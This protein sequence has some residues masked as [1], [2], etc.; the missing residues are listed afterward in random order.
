MPI[1][2]QVTNDWQVR[3]NGEPFWTGF[4]DTDVKSLLVKAGFA[5]ERAVAEYEPLGQGAY[6]FFGGRK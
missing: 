2:K 3:N 5:P 4:A 6:Y 1:P